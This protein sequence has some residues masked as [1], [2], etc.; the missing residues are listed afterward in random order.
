VLHPYEPDVSPCADAQPEVTSICSTASRRR[1]G[2]FPA[3]PR[4]FQP[5]GV[6]RAGVIAGFGLVRATTVPAAAPH[7]PLVGAKGRWMPVADLAALPDGAI[8]PF[9]VGAVQ[10][11]LINRGG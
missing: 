1:R 3:E 7:V 2:L 10:G 9:M 8:K 11:F 6:W 5:L 4:S